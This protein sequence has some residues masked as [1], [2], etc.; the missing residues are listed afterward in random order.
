[1][2]ASLGT[3]TSQLGREDERG[4]VDHDDG[5]HAVRM[6]SGQLQDRGAPHAVPDGH[7]LFEA[8]LLNHVRDVVRIRCDRIRPLGFVALAVST[9]VDGH[10]PMSLSKV[11]GLR[12]E[13]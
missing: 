4:R 10:N 11:L 13:E 7:D 6:G 12:G 1:M 2:A 9:Q 5:R 8:Q 3:R